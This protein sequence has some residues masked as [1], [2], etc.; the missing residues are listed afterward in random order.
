MPSSNP[1][2]PNASRPD[3]GGLLNS[4]KEIATYLNRSIVTVRRWEKKEAL[5]VHRDKKAKSV[6][7]RAYQ[8]E[9]DQWSRAREKEEQAEAGGAPRVPLEAAPATEL[10]AALEAESGLETALA[11]PPDPEPAAEAEPD[12]PAEM[13]SSGR[14]P[15][16]GA[17]G[18]SLSDAPAGE[19]LASWKKIAA[20]LDKGVG[21]VKGL[22]KQKGLP[23]HR[24][25]KTKRAAIWAYTSELDAWLR[26]TESAPPTEAIAE[27]EIQD[28]PLPL[29]DRASQPIAETETL[30]AAE[31]SAEPE[32][33]PAS[34]PEPQPPAESEILSEVEV[35]PE[36]VPEFF[37]ETEGPA[38]AASPDPPGPASVSEVEAPAEQRPAEPEIP[39]PEPAAEPAHEM[40]PAEA[41]EAAAAPEPFVPAPGPPPSEDL[42]NSWREIAA[43]FDCSVGTVRRWEKSKGLP[44]HRDRRQNL[45]WIYAY[46]WEL[47]HWGQAGA[48]HRASH[49]A[50]SQAPWPRHRRQDDLRRLQSKPRRLRLSG[51]Q[52]PKSNCRQW[53]TP[54]TPRSRSP[55]PPRRT[56]RGRCRPWC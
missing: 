20:Y 41:E 15:S 26:Q 44:V 48:S 3:R 8:S 7:I 25:A 42:L 37:S 30:P 10:D 14:Q 23:V 22:A 21:K 12:A 55:N 5:P 47:E 34:E 9:L 27:P 56:P 35:A 45:V 50:R 13:P 40:E 6:T 53:T 33:Q 46:R 1:S 43:Y 36:I 39:E 29:A 31:A 49:R 51:C 2:D 19:R 52:P 24:N 11:E 28:Q 38:A 16:V 17:D 54:R 18:P 32:R 4:W